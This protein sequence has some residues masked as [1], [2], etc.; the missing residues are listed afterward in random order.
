[1]GAGPPARDR[2]LAPSLGEGKDGWRAMGS[3][4]AGIPWPAE[5]WLDF[6]L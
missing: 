5:A 1:M 2:E 6:P 3:P 4:A